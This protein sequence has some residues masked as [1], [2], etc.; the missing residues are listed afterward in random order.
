M[1]RCK[2]LSV[3]PK[4]QKNTKKLEIQKSKKYSHNL[5]HKEAAY[6]IWKPQAQQLPRYDVP[7]LSGEQ[8]QQQEEEEGEEDTHPGPKYGNF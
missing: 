6:Q 5:D 1:T 3:F 4:I 2:K 7:K 8:Q